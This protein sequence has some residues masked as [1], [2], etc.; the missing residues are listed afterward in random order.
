M[1]FTV[2]P[3]GFQPFGRKSVVP[4]TPDG[5]DIDH[6]NGDSDGWCSTLF[7]AVV[8]AA[9]GIRWP[10]MANDAFWPAEC[11]L[12]VRTFRTQCRHID[13]ALDFFALAPGRSHDWPR[14]VAKLGIDLGTFIDTTKR[15]RDGPRWQTRGKMGRE[16]L[17]ALG[18]P[19][20]SFVRE[21]FDIGKSQGFWG[22]PR[23]LNC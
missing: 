3:P 18:L 22:P 21:L 4:L 17:S 2:Y 19:R 14:L 11:S 10:L 12:P 1:S 7:Q 20:R 15:A 8:D 23:V 9:R 13:G 16:I 6:K 5:A